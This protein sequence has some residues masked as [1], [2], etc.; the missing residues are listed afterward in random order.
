MSARALDLAGQQRAYLAAD[1]GGTPRQIYDVITGLAGI[2]RVLLAAAQ[3]GHDTEP[4]L[5]AALATLTTMIS[6]RHGTRPGWWSPPGQRPGYAAPVLSGSADTGLA[7]GIAG[8]IAF[9]S[10]AHMAG[11]SVSGQITAI[12]DAAAWLIRWQADGTW[13][14]HVTGTELDTGL[15]APT[16]GR[17]DA[18]CYGAP[19]ISRSLTLAGKAIGDQAFTSSAEAAVNA[20]T[21]RLPAGWDCE[22]PTLCHGY[23]GVL[24]V[25]SAD[26]AAQA[27]TG[28]FDHQTP[29]AFQ[30]VAAQTPKDQ[31]GF[32]TGAAGV[33]LALADH[34]RLPAR[35]VPARWDTLLLLS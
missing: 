11:Y 6:S 7:H 32:L 23:A 5:L 33:A 22:G 15:A 1:A 13:P 21:T 17:R 24:Q 12:R 31:P 34:A 30:H 4:G 10:L 14:P 19:G 28:Q 26:C 29:F 8:P 25:T 27:V 35:D 16:A 2:G 20:V 18:W 9:L 3:S